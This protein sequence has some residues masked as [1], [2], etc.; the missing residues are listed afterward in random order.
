MQNLMESF[1]PTETPTAA[2]IRERQAYLIEKHI[3]GFVAKAD[4]VVKGSG[5][6][7]SGGGDGSGGGGGSGDG[8]EE[9]KSDGSAGGAPGSTDSA[10]RGHIDL[11]PLEEHILKK[12]EKQAGGLEIIPELREIEAQINT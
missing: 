2:A 9:K 1:C 8:K 12:N 4:D 10:K 6:G 3:H 5:D 11:G 7:G